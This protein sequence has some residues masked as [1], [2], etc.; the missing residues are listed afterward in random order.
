MFLPSCYEIESATLAYPII[1]VRESSTLIFA[2]IFRTFKVEFLLFLSLRRLLPIILGRYRCWH[3]LP[4]G[5]VCFIHRHVVVGIDR[6]QDRFLG[7]KAFWRF[8][9][10]VL[11]FLRSL[12][13]IPLLFISDERLLVFFYSFLR[14]HF[15]FFLFILINDIEYFVIFRW[16]R[17]RRLIRVEN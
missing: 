12:T 17:G 14:L 6:L 3:F 5:K 7:I 10:K 2:E 13:E 15:F 1:I 11:I 4:L 9:D 16:E 8:S